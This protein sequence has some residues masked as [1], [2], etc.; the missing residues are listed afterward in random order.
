MKF[1]GTETSIKPNV[2]TK[3]D[4]DGRGTYVVGYFDVG[5]GLVYYDYFYIPSA[6]EGFAGACALIGLYAMF[7]G[8]GIG[9]VGLLPGLLPA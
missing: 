4:R 7:S 6:D 5:T 8:C 1:G 2:F 3:R 9:A